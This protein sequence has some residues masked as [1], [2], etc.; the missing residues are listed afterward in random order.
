MPEAN[1]KCFKCYESLVLGC[2]TAT[3]TPMHPTDAGC[4]YPADQDVRSRQ[5][6]DRKTAKGKQKERAACDMIGSPFYCAG[7]RLLCLSPARK[8]KWPALRVSDGQRC[9]SNPFTALRVN[10]RKTLPFYSSNP[11]LAA[12][13]VERSGCC[14]HSCRAVT[15][16]WSNQEWDR[17][18]QERKKKTKQ[19]RDKCI[20]SN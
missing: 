11:S 6:G 12:R 8:G 13:W 1:W 14:S 15:W 17:I 7:S 2:N 19:G 20:F 16:P 10:Q 9:F 5:M 4:I 3:C 18:A